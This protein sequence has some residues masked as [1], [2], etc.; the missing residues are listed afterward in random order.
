MI[1]ATAFIAL[2]L[3]AIVQIIFLFKRQRLDPFSHFLLLLAS[4]LLFTT[5]IQRSMRINFVAVTN[6]FESLV[7]FSATLT[8]L[9]FIYR[10]KAG[11]KS[12]PFIIFGTTVTAL[13]LL[14]V[15]SSPIAPREIVPLVPA[16]QSFWLVLHVTLSFIGE[17]FFVFGFISAICYLVTRDERKKKQTRPFYLYGYRDRLPHLYSRGADIRCYLGG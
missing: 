11:R 12:L 9:L 13:T 17:A 15:A 5:V 7:F 4:L 10:L 14:A 8:L 2:V 6:T 16:L 3:S 1:A